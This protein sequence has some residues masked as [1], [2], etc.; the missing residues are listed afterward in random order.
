MSG[1]EATG[2]VVERQGRGGRTYAIRFRAY[3]ERHFVTLGNQA[4]GWT[5]ARAELEL[6]N[7]LAD[8]RRGLWR[9]AAPPKPVEPPPDPTFHE[10]AS[11]WFAA[12]SPE[13][14]P[15]T[16]VSYEWA[17]RIHLLPFFARH[18]ISEITIAEVDRYRAYKVRE[19]QIGARS[20]NQTITRL[21][22]ILEYAVEYDL[23][24]RN[25]A[26]GRRRRLKTPPANRPWLDRA[27][28]IAAL[29]DAAGELDRE[30]RADRRAL[31]R[32][33]T[34]ATL[35][36]AGLRIGELCQLRWRDVDLAR[37]RISVNQS[38]TDA[39]VRRVD[40]LLALRDELLAHKATARNTRPDDLVFCSDAGGARDKDT[41]RN[42]VLAP[43][44]ERATIRL[45]QRGEDP[46]P[47]RLTLHGLRH[48]FAS[49]L[50]ALGEDPRYVMSQLGHSDPAFTLR[51]YTHT[52]RRDDG[53]RERLRALVEGANWAQLGTNPT[54]APETPPVSR[55]RTQRK[56][57]RK[58]GLRKARPAG[59]EPA[60]SCSGGKRS[61]H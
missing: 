58:Q 1:P 47:P 51:L 55:R 44:I 20:I 25:P 43:A 41:V 21:A 5:R 10:F 19:G 57:K 60:A 48:T 4:D 27:A 34:L 61:I 11:N 39:G 16:Q 18:R 52:M 33:A 9:P 24:A 29:L 3:G 42:R 6:R 59:F 40:L 32:R 31:A 54:M 7:V 12:R 38:K 35:A 45:E 23:I 22:Q 53:E 56:T 36:F 26:Q 28:H 49:L 37:G 50:V 15:T 8:V 46:L 17:L 30:A 2:Q 14:R 13:L